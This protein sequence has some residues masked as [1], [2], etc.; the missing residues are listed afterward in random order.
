MYHFTENFN[1]TVAIILTLLYLYQLGYLLLGFAC[2][3]GKTNC[4]PGKMHRFA[5]IISARNE[6]NVIGSLI[7]SLKAQNYPKE[8]LDIYVIADNCTDRTA[9][10]AASAGA[11]V[12]HRYNSHQIGKGYALDFLFKRLA[13]EG[14]DDYN[15]YFVFDADNYVDPDFVKEMNV[16]F[17]SGDYAALTSYRNSKNFGANWISAGYGLWFLREARFLNAP[18]MKLG[19]NCAISGTGFLVSGDVIRENGGWPFHLLTEDIEF[20]VNCALKGQ[21]IGYC[22]KAV[23]YDEQP[24][25]FRQSWDQRLR[26]S[27]GFY[28]VDYHYSFPLIR[29]IF[30][31]LR[32]GF[33]CY[34]MFMTVAPGMLLTMAAIWFNVMILGSALFLPQRMA[35]I[36]IHENISFIMETVFAFYLGLL[37]YGALTAF[38]EWK[39]ISMPGRKKL[40]YIF[41]FPIFMFTYIPIAAVA[42]VSRVEWRPIYHGANQR[43]LSGNRM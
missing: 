39:K 11:F 5:A 25:T 43:K 35:R 28:Q 20:S 13:E 23:V 41:T 30:S 4:A 36:L 12:Y 22:E 14:K 37:L 2:R 24:I 21:M 27:K 38:S 3:K 31:G 42:L 18:R 33:S 34:D 17:G 7:A 6:E 8:L 32:K 9:Q 29:S 10:I 1:T 15:G 26:W 40:L 16:T 19:V